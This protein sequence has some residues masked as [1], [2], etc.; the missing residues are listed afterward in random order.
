V[1]HLEQLRYRLLSVLLENPDDPEN[2]DPAVLTET[3]FGPGPA[4]EQHNLVRTALEALL[5]SRR[6]IQRARSEE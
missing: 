1:P 3:F 5:D 2:E 6:N 4:A